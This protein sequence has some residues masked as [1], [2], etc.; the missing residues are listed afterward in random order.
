MAR[1]T[2]A[3]ILLLGG[4]LILVGGDLPDLAGFAGC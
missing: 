1:L 2:I 4:K 3:S